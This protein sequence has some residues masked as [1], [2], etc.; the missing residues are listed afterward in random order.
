VGIEAAANF[1][2]IRL[3]RFAFLRQPRLGWLLNL[4]Y[5]FGAFR[6]IFNRHIVNQSY[7]LIVDGVDES[8]RYMLLNAANAPC[9]GG[10][11]CAVPTAMPDDGWIDLMTGTSTNRLRLLR[12]VVP[13]TQ[14][15]YKKFPGSLKCRRVKKLEL[16]SDAP[17]TIDL[18]GEVFYDT[19]LTVEIVP[20][21]LKF[22]VPYDLPFVSRAEK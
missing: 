9:Y 7:R 2:Y 19:H 3:G 11:K 8:G 22:V 12:M 5:T 16:S 17:L 14:G 1:A 18:D 15:Q 4:L 13:Y 21:S 10:D 20:N 6:N